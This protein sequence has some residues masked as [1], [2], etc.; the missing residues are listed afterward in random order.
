MTMNITE[1]ITNEISFELAE[2]L[3]KTQIIQVYINS[4]INQYQWCDSRF[5]ETSD[6][7]GNQSYDTRTEMRIA[8]KKHLELT[9]DF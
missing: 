1:S 8:L 3:R 6:V 7:W 5:K 2:F 4:D 9:G